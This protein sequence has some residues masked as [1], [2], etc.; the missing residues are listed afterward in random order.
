MR[1]KQIE[2]SLAR[3]RHE[4][5]PAITLNL[6][7]FPNLDVTMCDVVSA[8]LAKGS[9]HW[10][11]QRAVKDLWRTLPSASGLYMFIFSSPLRLRCNIGVH[12]PSWVLYVGRAGS[13]AAAYSIKDRYR[14]NYARYVEGDPEL[15]WSAEQV[16]NRD[17]KL[18]RYL[19]IYPLEFWWLEVEDLAKIKPLEDH[20]IKMLDPLLNKTQKLNLRPSPPEPAFIGR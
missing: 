19:T 18:Q 3:H 2:E 7:L 11:R 5:P 17:Q 14:Q 9:H 8:D 20:L 15:L 1:E 12:Q 10:E 6:P 16:V 4:R 13:E